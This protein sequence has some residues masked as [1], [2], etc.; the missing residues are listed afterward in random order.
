MFPGT[1]WDLSAL[2]SDVDGASVEAPIERL[3]SDT[4]RYGRTL[5]LLIVRGGRIV[6]EVHAD[7]V[8]HATTL[9]SWSMAKS[10]THALVGIAVGDGLLDIDRSG[11]FDE[12]SADERSTITLRHLLNMSSGLEWVEDYVDG[13]TSD[14]IEMLYG[15]GRFAGDHAAFAIAKKL[16]AAPGTRY[17]YSSGTTNI[18]TRIL[19][20]SLGETEGSSEAVAGF[21][22]ERLFGPIGMSSATP[23]FD[24]T[25]NFVGSSYVYATARDFARFGWLYRNDGVWNGVRILPSGW[26]DQGRTPVARDPDNGFDYGGHWWVHPSDPGSMTALG[27]EGQFTWVSPRRDLVLVRL[28]RSDAN[29]APLVKDEL[30]GIVGAF[31]VVGDNGG[32][33]E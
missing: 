29:Q 10:I 12:W 2:G 7:G 16:E 6:R 4:S 13:S 17:K 14:V 23:K 27:Y 9:I 28:G 15:D 1:D 33:H 18:V 11:L 21:M 32:R 5:S 26:V 20:R 30:V 19:A 22:R 25:G 24:K 8:D 3:F 31:P